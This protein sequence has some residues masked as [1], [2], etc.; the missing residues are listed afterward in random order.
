LSQSILN[1]QIKRIRDTE[2][3]D[4]DDKVTNFARTLFEKAPKKS[5]SAGDKRRE[6]NRAKEKAALELQTK[7]YSLVESGILFSF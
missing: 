3:L 6:E 4:V 7:R 2:T 5:F 1:F